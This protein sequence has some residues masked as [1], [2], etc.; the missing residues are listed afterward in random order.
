M[1]QGNFSINKAPTTLKDAL[2]RCDIDRANSKFGFPKDQVKPP[3]TRTTPSS[4]MGNTNTT[5]QPPN[6]HKTSM[7]NPQTRHRSSNHAPAHTNYSLPNA[8]NHIL[9]TCSSTGTGG[10]PVPS[11]PTQT[12]SSIPSYEQPNPNRSEYHNALQGAPMSV[13]QASVPLAEITPKCNSMPPPTAADVLLKSSLFV[14]NPVG[15]EKNHRP[16]TSNGR[17]RDGNRRISTD[18][19][20]PYPPAPLVTPMNSSSHA[21]NKRPNFDGAVNVDPTAVKKPNVNPYFAR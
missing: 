1:Y 12:P 9:N 5:T 3:P 17:K 13:T 15:S 20:L 10:V 11:N 16:N 18:S 4:A 6:N 19:E 21:G 14:A 7:A 8:T 2:D